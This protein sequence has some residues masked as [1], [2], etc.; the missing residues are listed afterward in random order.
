M[1]SIMHFKTELMALA[2]SHDIYQD[3]KTL[4]YTLVEILET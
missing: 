1:V 3:T 4:I 2:S